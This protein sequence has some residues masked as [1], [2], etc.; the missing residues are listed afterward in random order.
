MVR[1][2]GITVI[3]VFMVLLVGCQSTEIEF[4]T[5]AERFKYEY[6]SVNGKLDYSWQKARNVSIDDD[7]P[8]VYASYSDLID[9]IDSGETFA[10]YFGY[11]KCPWCRGAIEA[12]LESAKEYG[13]QTLY[14]VDVY[15]SRDKYEVSNGQA[16][17]KSEG[18]EGYR[19]LIVLLAP[20]LDDYILEDDDGSEVDTGE[21]RIYA[22][23]VIV[24][25]NGEAVGI[26]DDSELFTD[27]YGEIT[28]EIYS[29]MV[30]IY[31]EVFA[32]LTY[33]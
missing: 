20:V 30:N 32:M 3:L 8:I 4:E 14:Y 1:R 17:L 6:E 12:I 23:N 22:P 10:V 7:N 28:D 24:V 5:D 29:D 26:A 16:V 27:P 25:K 21:K 31:S 11:N 18:E 2:A 15:S 13:V 19:E 9:M 33:Q